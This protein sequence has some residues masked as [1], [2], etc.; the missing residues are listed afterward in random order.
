MQISPFI[1]KAKGKLSNSEYMKIQ[2]NS[3]ISFS[4][5]GWGELGA[6]DY[7]II[8]GGSLLIK[9]RM[10][11]MKTW[12]NIFIPNKTYVPLEWDFNNL[13][14]IFETYITNHKLRNEIVCNSQEA[15]KKV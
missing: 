14:E 3:K 13:E 12:P 15:Y 9:P 4:P 11:H 7:E 8:L 6:R 2:N 5:F 10:D 1:K